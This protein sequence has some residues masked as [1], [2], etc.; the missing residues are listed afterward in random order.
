MMN[1][2][3]KVPDKESDE[4]QSSVKKNTARAVSL[5]EVTIIETE[6]HTTNIPT[7]LEA[8]TENETI[9]ELE[10]IVP[11]QLESVPLAEF[12]DLA[13]RR[14]SQPRPITLR[15]SAIVPTPPVA[16]A[17]LSPRTLA[18]LSP[19]P[20]LR[21]HI[22]PRSLIR[23]VSDSPD[24]YNFNSEIE[25]ELGPTIQD[26][27]HIIKMRNY[28][29]AAAAAG[30]GVDKEGNKGPCV[31]P[32]GA[33]IIGYSFVRYTRTLTNA[34]VYLIKNKMIDFLVLSK[35]ALEYDLRNSIQF[36]GSTFEDW[37]RGEMNV[38][39]HIGAAAGTVW[40]SQQIIEHFVQNSEFQHD[41]VVYWADMNGIPVVCPNLEVM[42]ANS[43]S[44]HRF[45][46]L[47]LNNLRVYRTFET[48]LRK[49]ES[50]ALIVMGEDDVKNTILNAV[51][52]TRPKNVKG[53][54]ITLAYDSML[55]QIDPR[56]QPI[57]FESNTILGDP[58]IIF[59]LLLSK[60][61]AVSRL[62]N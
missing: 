34:I 7:E 43:I 57:T 52:N 60:T 26:L 55:T 28:S 39:L 38:L 30:F 4:Q 50:L 45:V 11:P 16:I 13:R 62:C 15:A 5:E 44:N 18:L 33:V 32:N 53:V 54:F 19:T 31:R 23:D 17:R 20:S 41:S 51:I 36:N 21:L 58:S 1:P 29:A 56:A 10:T 27:C 47:Q 48:F 35:E 40:T 14:Q 22:T 3:E 25:V 2:N 61:F 24:A 42:I 49:C 37:L 9:P 6:T 8:P 46:D 12:C 59:P